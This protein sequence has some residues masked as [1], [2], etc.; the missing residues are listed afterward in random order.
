M[1]YYAAGL[2]LCRSQR[3]IAATAHP[4]APAPASERRLRAPGS[5][6]ALKVLPCREGETQSLLPRPEESI[7]VPE[8]DFYFNS[9]VLRPFSVRSKSA[10]KLIICN[11]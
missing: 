8:L 2:A 6:P 3:L 4:R 1:I 10:A 9:G 11:A 5:E 7:M